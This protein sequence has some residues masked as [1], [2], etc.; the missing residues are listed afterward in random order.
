MIEAKHE[1]AAE[2]AADLLADAWQ[3]IEAAKRLAYIEHCRAD[4]ERDK[5][6][7]FAFPV[8][9]TL[10]LSFADG[11]PTV[12]GNIAWGNRYR[13]EAEARA[14][15]PLPDA[16]PGLAAVGMRVT[17]EGGGVRVDVGPDGVRGEGGAA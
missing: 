16:L 6:T 15:G 14:C 5:D 3:D 13:R 1:A 9:L 11:R 10:A 12:A 8:R 2:L 17:M 7:P 4:Q